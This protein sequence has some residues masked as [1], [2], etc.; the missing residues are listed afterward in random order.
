MFLEILCDCLSKE[1]LFSRLGFV[2]LNG[3]TPLTKGKNWTHNRF[4]NSRRLAVLIIRW[5]LHSV[6]TNA[7]FGNIMR[8]FI[9]GKTFFTTGLCV[10]ERSMPL[11]MLRCSILTR[12]VAF[13]FNLSSRYK[14]CLDR[15]GVPKV[16]TE[17]RL[18][19]LESCVQVEGHVF[20]WTVVSSTMSREKW[21][22]HNRTIKSF[23]DMLRDF[24]MQGYMS[25]QKIMHHFYTQ[26]SWVVWCAS[27]DTI[28]F[29]RRLTT[30][31]YHQ[32]QMKPYMHHKITKHVIEWFYKDSIGQRTGHKWVSF[33]IECQVSCT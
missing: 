7:V 30:H 9:K 4:S 23:Y 19:G 20:P 15:S 24:V 10:A 29:L 3:W 26:V 18:I 14:L 12:N 32:R 8:L 1:K 31:R 25:H 2:L 11:G 27:F 16:M 13:L 21:H 28:F 17:Q 22:H 5:R 33:V 6:F